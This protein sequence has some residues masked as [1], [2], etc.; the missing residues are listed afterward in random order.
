MEAAWE[1]LGDEGL[2][3]ELR[4]HVLRGADFLVSA[5]DRASGLPQASV[6]LWEQQD[7]QHTYTAAAIVGGLRAAARSAAR[8][9]RDAR[10]EKYAAVAAGIAAAIDDLLW[11]EAHG[12][13]RRAVNVARARGGETRPGTAFDRSLPYPNRRVHGV[14]PVDDTLDCSL[15]GLVWPFRALDPASERVRA[16]V[17]AVAEGLAGA[18]GGHRRQ[19]GD[20]YA[21]GHEWLLATLWLGLARRVLGDTAALDRAIAHVVERRTELDLLAEQVDAEGRPAWV[22]PLGWSHAM[23]L[24]ASLPELRLVDALGVGK[25]AG[26]GRGG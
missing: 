17:D 23:L 15:L 11:D 12:R 22:L 8:H 26:D 21:G 2:D 5:V 6:D 1:E 25:S 9:S 24:L 3:E 4:E 13:Y 19:A 7:G 18:G 20:T 14:A 16:T 10:A